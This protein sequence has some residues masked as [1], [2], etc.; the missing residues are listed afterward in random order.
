MK[1]N[2]NKWFYEYHKYLKGSRNGVIGYND[3]K[4]KNINQIMERL[5]NLNSSI[6]EEQ[7]F[8]VVS[9]YGGFDRLTSLLDESDYTFNDLNE[10]LIDSYRMSYENAMSRM[11]VN[12]HAVI[13]NCSSNDKDVVHQ[14]PTDQKY[15]VVDVPFNQMHFG[16]RDEMIRQYIRE[17][18]S[19]QN[20]FYMS[21][22]RFLSPNVRSVLGFVFIVTTNGLICNDWGVAIDDKG[23]HFKVS[24]GKG[25]DVNFII[26]KLD[27][28]KVLDINTTV[29]AVENGFIPLSTHDTLVG[30]NCIVD[31]F[32]NTRKSYVR[33]VPNFGVVTDEGLKLNFVQE[34][35]IT[36]ITRFNERNCRILVYIP[37]YLFEAPNTYP[38]ANFCDMLYQ[39][40]IMTDNGDDVYTQEGKQISGVTNDFND[41]VPVCTPPISLVRSASVSFDTVL[42]AMN[43]N[44]DMMKINDKMIQLGW[45]INKDNLIPYEYNHQ[46]VIPAS[47]ML[48]NVEAYYETYMRAGILTSFVTSKQK[49]KFQNFINRFRKF[50]TAVTNTPNMYVARSNSIDEFYGIAYSELVNDLTSVFNVGP[51]ETFRKFDRSV[52]K[53]NYFNDYNKN[54]RFTRPMSEQCFIALKYSDD[55]ECW[56]FTCPNIKHFHGIGNT[57]YINDGLKGNEVFKFLVLYTDT[58]DPMEKNIETFDLDTVIDFDK[59]CE[60]V[61]S[62]KAYIR[63]WNVENHLRK[64]AK[65]LYNDDSTDKQFHVLSK[66]LLR[67]LNGEEFLDLYPTD[68]N[69]EESN[70]TSDN[71]NEYDEGSA[72]APFSVNFLFYTISMMYDNKDQLLSYFI[73]KLTKRNFSNRYVDINIADTIRINN[74]MLVN[75]SCFTEDRNDTIDSFEIRELPSVSSMMFYGIPNVFG[76][77]GVSLLS[78][79]RY[80]FTFTKNIDGVIHYPYITDDS[81]LDLDHYIGNPLN[82]TYIDYTPTVNFVKCVYEYGEYCDDTLNIIETNFVSSFD[83]GNELEVCQQK[84]ESYSNKL[85]DMI[86]SGDVS[87]EIQAHDMRD[88][89]NTVATAVADLKDNIT[90]FRHNIRYS[91]TGSIIQGNLGNI[92]FFINDYLKKLKEVFVSVG[93]DDFGYERI[94]ALYYH[95]KKINN[96]MSLHVFKHWLNDIDL[97]CMRN[98]SKVIAENINAEDYTSTDINYFDT[99]YSRL[100]DFINNIAP[101]YIQDIESIYNSIETTIRGNLFYVLHNVYDRLTQYISTDLYSITEVSINASPTFQNKP[102]YVIVTA[103]EK[104]FVFVPFSETVSGGYKIK[105]LNPVC[106]Y[107]LFDD[108]SFTISALKVYDENGTEIPQ[109][110]SMLITVGLTKVGNVTDDM[111]DV[112]EIPDVVHM[113][114]PFQH[115]HEKTETVGNLVATV[116]NA[117]M[118]YELLSGNRFMPLTYEQELVLDKNTLLPGPVDNV[119]LPSMTLNK[120]A[121]MNIGNHDSMSLYFKPVQVVHP[122]TSVGRGYHVGQTVY[123]KTTDDNNYVF[124]IIVT[125]IDHDQAHGFIEAIVDYNNAKWFK[126]TDDETIRDYLEYPV[127]CEVIDDNISNFMDEFSNSEYVNYQVPKLIPNNNDTVYTLPGDPLYVIQNADYVYT[128]LSWFFSD[129]IPNRFIDEEHKQ[130]HFVYINSGAIIE[131]GIMTIS[132]INHNFSTLTPPELYPVLRDEPNDHAVR[133]LEKQTFTRMLKDQELKL[134]VDVYEYEKALADYF[135]AE[136]SYEKLICKLKVEHAE[137]QVKQTK[138]FI[139]RLEDY[140]N[141]PESPTTWYNLYAYDDA[142]TYINN[143]RSKMSHLPR[144][145]IR[146]IVYTDKIEIQMYD[147]EH[148]RRRC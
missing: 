1:I 79:S 53:M 59:F 99:A 46:I 30:G 17:M 35:A 8:G 93:F 57:F 61:D 43:L 118:N 65:I 136:T 122:S 4:W 64:I 42:D 131:N 80:D 37:K 54:T 7:P 12:T 71:I 27:D 104:D 82:S 132:M 116:K 124:P 138:A 19:R 11:L 86:Q 111:E 3:T 89:L 88:R 40:P 33:S 9:N 144:F 81:D 56:V 92:Y 108:D 96:A 105:E 103:R 24:W 41:D 67:K 68:M 62:Y 50:V 123:V 75:Y 120:F 130:Y 31:I 125:K 52:F 143:G 135:D 133:I 115:V 22:D 25:Y 77:N 95:M 55:E 137:L 146:D 106:D 76:S 45:N 66:M 51:L 28:C 148:N 16:D 112:V 6:I 84:M 102:K 20:N 101:S 128:R 100:N 2:Y 60:E 21:M 141:Q 23:F 145:N 147:W 69:Y 91:E 47:E 15:Y 85:Y 32:D 10:S 109:S 142:I 117:N 114:Y 63:Y 140:I 26:Y 39:H 44:K 127:E 98:L 34:R 110:S 126:I 119:N 5:I 90:N 36:D 49:Y 72:R 87:V 58:E 13:S 29:D 14:Y 107:A 38:A 113:E 74:G 48:K 83:I 121:K 129:G 18:Y 78:S 139:T 70:V 94:S 134:D 73:N 97:E